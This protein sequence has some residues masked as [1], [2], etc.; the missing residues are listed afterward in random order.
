L[1]R[2]AFRHVYSFCSRRRGRNVCPTFLRRGQERA[3]NGLAFLYLIL[4]R[5]RAGGV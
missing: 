2:Q 5:P 3:L 4:E 1:A